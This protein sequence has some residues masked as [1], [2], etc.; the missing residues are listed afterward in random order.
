MAIPEAI[1]DVHNTIHIF[2]KFSPLII[3]F[4][5]V[6]LFIRDT[7]LIPMSDRNYSP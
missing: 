1:A 7:I 4:L 3:N 2:D 5:I 6:G